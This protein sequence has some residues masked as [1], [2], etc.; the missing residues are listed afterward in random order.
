MELKRSIFYKNL[1]ALYKLNLGK[2]NEVHR[3]IITAIWDLFVLV[4]GD[5]DQA[6][7]QMCLNTATGEWLDAWGDY[8]NIPREPN[9]P[10]SS[11][12]Q[13][14]VDETIEP[15]VTLEAIKKSTARWLNRRYGDE[16]TKDDISV[17]EP[18]KL[19]LKPSQRGTLSG[20]AKIMSA[21]YWT[22]GVIDI[23]LPN[24][25]EITFDLINYLSTIKAAGVKIMWSI[26][27][28]WDVVVGY[29]E[30]TNLW[31]KYL[32]N[33]NLNS[34][35]F[36]KTFMVWSGE[37][38][39]GWDDT[40]YQSH[41]SDSPDYKI[42][43]QRLIWS[44]MVARHKDLQ[45]VEHK[46]RR[47]EGSSVSKLDDFVALLSMPYE[48]LT[49]GDILDLEAADHSVFSGKITSSLGALVIRS[50]NL[51]STYI[52]LANNTRKLSE[53]PIYQILVDGGF[54]D[55]SDVRNFI[56]DDP[57]DG[58]Y[59]W[60]SLQHIAD[61]IGQPASDLTLEYLVENKSSIINALLWE[62]AI[63]D[64]IMAPIQVTN[65]PA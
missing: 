30:T 56:Y 29:W 28:S 25:S 47:Y 65:L 48:E 14:I 31:Y 60:L 64:N 1:R 53:S 45:K 61:V 24:S 41:L 20:A 43:G 19:L 8:F 44:E 32:R 38:F 42:S 40:D 62:E 54:T 33:L 51:T 63:I 17:V 5:V 27:P 7:L 26:R 11:Y 35:P 21:D 49:V 9:E 3:V 34:K 50:I 37:R 39:L 23:A 46:L 10:D 2:T 12:S 13:R 15:K 36:Y 55:T 57:N 4:K 22:Y 52:N 59:T 16:W 6:K 58:F 18:W